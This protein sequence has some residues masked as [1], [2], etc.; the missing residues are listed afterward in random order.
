MLTDPLVALSHQGQVFWL[1][2]SSLSS[3]K[4]AAMK[5]PFAIL[6]SLLAALL[7]LGLALSPGFGLLGAP[8]QARST[9]S[10]DPY[11]GL[12]VL[13][14]HEIAEG[15]KTLERDFAVTPESF[16][17]QIGWLAE[18]GYHFTSIDELLAAQAGRRRLPPRSV[19]L[20]FDD[21]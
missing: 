1:S 20:S 8:A 5:P 10:P 13:A 7:G 18:H 6:Q 3:G 16:Q 15:P 14:Y 9:A 2:I 21:G 17:A 11:R 4:V 12:I 19:L